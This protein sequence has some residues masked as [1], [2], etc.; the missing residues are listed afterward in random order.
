MNANSAE[1]WQIALT[2]RKT[3]QILVEIVACAICPLPIPYEV[4]V[5]PVNSKTLFSFH[6][7][8]VSTVN[9][10]GQTIPMKMPLDVLFSISENFPKK[11]LLLFIPNFQ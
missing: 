9:S 7:S 2:W 1:D 10:D 11:F 5:P 6:L 8:E 3:M 4:Y